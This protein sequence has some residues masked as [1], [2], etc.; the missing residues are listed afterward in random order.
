MLGGVVFKSV[1]VGGQIIVW[2][3]GD[4]VP[5]TSVSAFVGTESSTIPV[6][7][8][9]GAGMCVWLLFIPTSGYINQVRALV[10]AHDS[11]CVEI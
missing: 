6:S 9:L 5:S 3:V 11:R 2:S 10:L 1:A 8:Q 7:N 4:G